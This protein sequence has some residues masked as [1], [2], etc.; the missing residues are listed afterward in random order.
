[1]YSKGGLRHQSSQIGRDRPGLRCW[2]T[3]QARKQVAASPTVAEPSI[4]ARDQYIEVQ[5]V[6]QEAEEAFY[7]L[8]AVGSS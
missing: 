3:S 8:S 7:F 6:P 4:R 1:M 2:V 5:I